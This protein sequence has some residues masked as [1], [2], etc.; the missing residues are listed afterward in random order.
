MFKGEKH[1]DIPS[2]PKYILAWLIKAVQLF[3]FG[4]QDE[5]TQADT[6]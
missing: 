2:Y 6:T 1:T 4:S 5:K 3:F